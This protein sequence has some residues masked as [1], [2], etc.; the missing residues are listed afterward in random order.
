MTTHIGRPRRPERMATALY[1]RTRG[2]VAWSLTAAERE[3]VRYKF[4]NQHGTRYV[5]LDAS[6]CYV[7]RGSAAI[8]EVRH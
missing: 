1:N 5:F 8:A 2:S 6:E 4:A 3:Q 7:P